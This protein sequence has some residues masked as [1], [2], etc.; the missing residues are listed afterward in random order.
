M[1]A[2][3]PITVQDVARMGFYA[4]VQVH[5]SPDGRFVTYLYSPERSL[6]LERGADDPAT[7]RQWPVAGLPAAEATPLTRE[8]ELRRERQRQFATGVSSYAWSETGNTLL[9]RAGGNV[10]VQLG[11]DGSP[12]LVGGAE[13]LDPQLNRD[14]TRL[15]LVRDGE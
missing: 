14:G 1:T 9:V 7:G 11:L 15:A 3:R 8:E 4:P 13:C 5:W 6:R 10:F 2:P 12:R